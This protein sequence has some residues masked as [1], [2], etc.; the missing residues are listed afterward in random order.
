MTASEASRRK[1]GHKTLGNMAKNTITS[2]KHSKGYKTG[3]LVD[4]TGPAWVDGTPS[5]PELMLNAD[6]TE[7]MLRYIELMNK[8][9]L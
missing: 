6:D 2:G 4:Y 9:N 3:G 5:K 7:N 8:L 1:A